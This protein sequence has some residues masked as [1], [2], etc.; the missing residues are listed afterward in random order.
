MAGL[1]TLLSG[2]LVAALYVVVSIAAAAPAASPQS[3]VGAIYKTYR[4]QGSKRR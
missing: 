3:F 4:R 2:A 1:R